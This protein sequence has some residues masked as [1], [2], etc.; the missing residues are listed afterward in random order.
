MEVTN[1]ADLPA[2][3]TFLNLNATRLVDVKEITEFWKALTVEEKK[4]FGD[5]ARSLLVT[6]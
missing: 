6:V 1:M 3:R 4:Q 5:E 2:I